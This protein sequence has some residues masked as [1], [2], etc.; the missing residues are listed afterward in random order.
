METRAEILENGP[1]RFNKIIKVKIPIIRNLFQSYTLFKHH[2]PNTIES[3]DN[4]WLHQPVF[5]NKETTKEKATNSSNSNLLWATRL[6]AH[7][8]TKRLL[9]Q[10]DL[11]NT[12]HDR[13]TNWKQ[14]DPNAI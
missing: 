11:Q 1:A 8:A 7:T 9:P 3:G 4:T 12:K 5:Y 14:N 2:F 10:H 6:P 13:G